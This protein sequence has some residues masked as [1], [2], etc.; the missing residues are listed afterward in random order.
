MIDILYNK[1]RVDLNVEKSLGYFTKKYY[2]IYN[3]NFSNENNPGNTYK[4]Q[5]GKNE[6]G[7][8]FSIYWN[9]FVDTKKTFPMDTIE[10]FTENTIQCD[11]NSTNPSNGTFKKLF[12]LK[13][14]G[15]VSFEDCLGK[16]WK[17]EK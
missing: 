10:A 2:E 7:T 1:L 12:Y 13:Q 3:V 17:L 8:S 5:M 15:I 16:T 4:I 6:N 14:K 9:V 11:T